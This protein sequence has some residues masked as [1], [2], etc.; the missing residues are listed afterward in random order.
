MK[1]CREFKIHLPTLCDKIMLGES[2]QRFAIVLMG[3]S[4]WFQLRGSARDEGFFI[5]LVAL[6]LSLIGVLI[7]IGVFSTIRSSVFPE[8]P[9]G[10]LRED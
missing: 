8:D 2:L 6:F 9:G 4:L 3:V 5:L 7:D 1:F 10:P